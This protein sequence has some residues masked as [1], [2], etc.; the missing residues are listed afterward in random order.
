CDAHG[1]SRRRQARRLIEVVRRLNE[2]QGRN[3]PILYPAQEAAV[4][5][6]TSLY[7]RGDAFD[8]QARALIFAL[9]GDKGD[10]WD[11]ACPSR[12]ASRSY[13]RSM[14]TERA[15]TCLVPGKSSR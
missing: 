15:Q 10:S 14:R 8:A 9:I 13:L 3:G 2:R 5:S 6:A 11:R 4:T 7:P 12:I 1:A